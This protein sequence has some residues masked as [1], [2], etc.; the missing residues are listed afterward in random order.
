MPDIFGFFGEKDP[1]INKSTAES[2]L[3]NIFASFPD[4]E[5][6][7]QH[8]LPNS[9]EENDYDLVRHQLYTA[10]GDF[11]LLCPTTYFAEKFLDSGNNVY[12]YLWAHRPSDSPWAPW[13]GVTHFS[14]VSFLFGLPIKYAEEYEPEEVEL[15]MDFIHKWS[16]FVKYG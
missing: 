1:Q 13:M 8:Y 15:S 5:A 16:H 11:S 14:D 4:T 6:V 3:R 2:M 12:F 9:I 7:N 10:S